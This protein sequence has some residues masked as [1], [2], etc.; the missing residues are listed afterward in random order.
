MLEELTWRGLFWL[1]REPER[2]LAGTLNFSQERAELDLLGSFDNGDS[3]PC[4]NSG[5]VFS[6]TRL[7]ER[8]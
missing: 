7:T 1:P 5:I 2:R 8:S 4:Q 6:A 3:V